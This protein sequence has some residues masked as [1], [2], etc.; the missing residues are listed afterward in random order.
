MDILQK[1][2]ASM[3]GFSKGQKAI[4]KFILEHYDKAAY[5]T[6]LKLGT[7]VRVSEST[8]VRFA[9]ELGYDGYP[10]LQRSLRELIRTRLTS[11]QRIE[12]TN[13]R[14]EEHEVLEKVMNLDIEKM[15]TTLDNIDKEAFDNAVNAIIGARNIYIM[16][17]R[18]SAC[19]AVFMNFYLSLIFGN[20]KLV[21]STSRSE[22]FEQLFRIG[23]EDIIIG[24]SF[25]RYSKRIIQAME[26]A[27]EQKAMSVAITDS[28]DSPL[29]E[30]ADHTLIARSEMA[31]FVD[32]LVAPLSVINALIVAIGKKKQAEV[33]EIFNK[34]EDVWDEFEVYNKFSGQ[35]GNK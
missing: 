33:S 25:P 20:V 21:N 23:P 2:D 24:I 13:D 31:S 1:I 14:I 3:P 27:K 29:S 30:Y 6:A 7:T 5:M 12:I 35:V 15:K 34:L 19:L 10:D 22:I 18:S 32:S 4:G 26:F 28:M 17:M 9:I 11:L 16:G 8:V